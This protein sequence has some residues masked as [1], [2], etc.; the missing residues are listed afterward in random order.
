MDFINTS[1]AQLSDLF[2]SM[3]A[4]ARMTVGLLLAV[5]VVSLV[6]LFQ[7]RLR[8]TDGYLFGGQSFSAGEM[9]AMQA[10]FSQAGLGGWELEGNQIRIPKH[11]QHEYIAALF[12]N[13]ALPAN[14]G[15]GMREAL[16]AGGSFTT[17]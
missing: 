17:F 3:T 7:G 14:W 15:D 13:K 11:Q 4:G 2:K 9:Q 6:F 10:A 12:V 5:L 1:V 8:G 16:D